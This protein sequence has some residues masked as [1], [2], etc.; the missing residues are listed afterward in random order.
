[1][2]FTLIYCYRLNLAE[3]IPQLEEFKIR[4]I[5]DPRELCTISNL[6]FLD[7][8]DYLRHYDYD[9]SS[10]EEVQGRPRYSIQQFLL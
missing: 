8:D 1:M 4:L 5:T 3:E 2:S 7:D 10:Q 9:E 6:K